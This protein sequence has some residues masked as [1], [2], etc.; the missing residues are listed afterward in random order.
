MQDKEYDRVVYVG[1]GSNDF[2]PST[3][4]SVNDV[5]LPRIGRKFS[6]MLKNDKFK[7][8]IKARIVEW[9]SADDVLEIFKSI[10]SINE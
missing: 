7:S 10:L 2:C 6:K 5:V 8:Q 1:D 9:E 4:L 3:K